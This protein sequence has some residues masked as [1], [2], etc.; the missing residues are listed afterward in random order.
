MPPNALTRALVIGLV[1]AAVL[2]CAPARS[3]DASDGYARQEPR[4]IYGALINGCRL[5]SWTDPAGG[6]RFSWTDPGFQ[7][8]EICA[9]T[10]VLA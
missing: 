5:F 4:L 7:P 6:R 2:L 9:P 3:H 1:V 10:L 8:F